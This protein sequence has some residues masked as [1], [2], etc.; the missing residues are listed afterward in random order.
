MTGRVE[1]MERASFIPARAR[2]TVALMVAMSIMSY[3]NRTILSIASPHI[4]KEFGISETEMGSLYS[5]FLL[6]YAVLM[7]PAGRMA[8]VFGPRLV[9]AWVAAASAIFTALTALIG[10]LAAAAWFSLFPALFAVR[11]ALGIF[12]APLYPSIGRLTANWI[13]T[14]ARARVQS[15][16]IA[17]APLGGAITP[18]LCTWLIAWYGWKSSF[19]IAAAV[20]AVL[21][22]VWVSKV[23]D[24][25]TTKRQLRMGAE[26]GEGANWRR[27]LKNRNIW[28]LTLGY[29]MLNYFEYIFFYWIYYYFVVIRK[30]GAAQ[31]AVYTTTLLLAMMVSTPIGGWTTDRLGRRLGLLRGRRTVAVTGMVLSAVLLYLATNMDSPV[32]MVALMSLALGFASCSE[33]PFWA[34]LLEA[35]G[36][37]AGAAGGIMNGIGNVGGLIAP[38]LTPFIAARLGWTWSLHAGSILILTGALSWFFVRS[39]RTAKVVDGS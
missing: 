35:G 27:L 8:D 11:F 17:G 16:I 39:P 4:I 6:S 2:M 5:A 24:T 29:F 1:A 25:P 32:V 18:I 15:I 21:A 28:V 31:S 38:V 37:S 10:W 13:H 14:A 33:G 12:S 19:V 20:T 26:G 9:L 22:V 3:F 34:A 7:A 30:A 36:D 23:Q